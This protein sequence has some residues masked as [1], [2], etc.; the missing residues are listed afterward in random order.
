LQDNGVVGTLKHFPG[1]GDALEDA[2]LSLP[3]IKRT[4]D[5]IESVELAPYRA[6]IDAGKVQMVMTTD[7]LMPA[8]DPVLPAE[9]SPNI[10]T[11][12]LRNELGFDGVVMT[13]ALYMAGIADKWG[14]P[15]AGVMAI[16]AGCDI[17]LGPWN[18]SQM[19]SMVSAL[20]RALKNGSLTKARIDQS[21]ERILLLKMRMGLI[22][23]PANSQSLLQSVPPL[24]SMTLQFNDAPVADVPS[25]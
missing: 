16:Q 10:I 14:M 12:V 1:L 7:L 22:S 2:H 20:K 21:V 17:L 8:L 24:G 18:A 25:R 4:R 19:R 3:V 11:G 23:L 9:L 13:D 5:Q 15:Q 6:M